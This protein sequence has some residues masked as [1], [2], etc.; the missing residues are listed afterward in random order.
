MIS[1]L[2]LSA[3]GR[4]DSSGVRTNEHAAADVISDLSA[5]F[6]RLATAYTVLAF[7]PRATTRFA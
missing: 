5:S 6:Y 2:A 4:F 3:S 1:G 7:L